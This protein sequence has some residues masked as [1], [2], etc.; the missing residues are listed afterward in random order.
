MGAQSKRVQNLASVGANMK[1]HFIVG[2]PYGDYQKD[3]AC[4]MEAK[5]MLGNMMADDLYGKNKLESTP[6]RAARRDGRD[7]DVLSVSAPAG[8]GELAGRLAGPFVCSALSG[9]DSGRPGLIPG[10]QLRR[11]PFA[12]ATTNSL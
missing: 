11:L 4:Y 6:D 8:H 5:R 7:A 1:S 10:L 9:F 3:S 12:S 2:D